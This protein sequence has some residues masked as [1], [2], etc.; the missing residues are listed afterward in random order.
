MTPQ[1]ASNSKRET[2]PMAL[3]MLAVRNWPLVLLGCALGGMLGILVSRMINEKYTVSLLLQIDSQ[4]RRPAG[5]LGDMAEMFQPDARAET[6]TEL[7]QSRA[8]IESVVDSLGLD[9]FSMSK[10]KIRKLMRKSGRLDVVAL[11]I[12]R[13]SEDVKDPWTAVAI[14]D[15]M[16]LLRNPDKQGVLQ[17]RLGELTDTVIGPDTIRFRFDSLKA[18]PGEVFVVAKLPRN[19]VI[20]AILKSL[21][22][23]EKGR[24]TGVLSLT[25]TDRFP[26]RARNVLNAIAHNYVQQN[27]EVRSSD[28]RK[29]LNYLQLQ[30]PKIRHHLDSLEDILKNYQFEKGTVNINS[31]AQA[32]LREQTELQ[33]QAL[34]IQQKR[35]EALRLYRE[36]HPNLTVL[37]NQA[38]Q[39][40]AALAKA[41]QEVKRLPLTQQAVARL[42][43][44]V[45][46]NT[47]LFTAILNNIQQ[48]Q[49]IQGGEVGSARIVDPAILPLRPS[50]LPSK[51]IVIAGILFGFTVV[52]GLL[53]LRHVFD[54]GIEDAASLE[55]ATSLPV[56]AQ[57]P[58]S[59]AQSK[60]SRK[61]KVGESLPL[62]NSNSGDLAVEALRSLRTSLNLTDNAS[63]AKIVTISGLSMGDGKSF[64]ATNVACLFAQVGKRVILIDSDLRR[65][66]LGEQFGIVNQLGLADYLKGIVPEA[67]ILYPTKQPNLVVIPAGQYPSNPAELLSGN[68]MENLLKQLAS[69]A[70]IILL[71]TPPAMMVSDPLF[72]MKLS[73]QTLLVLRAGTHEMDTVQEALRRLRLASIPNVGFVLNKC[74]WSHK[75]MKYYLQYGTYETRNAALQP[76]A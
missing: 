45:E 14:S 62:A 76:K 57:V 12:P 52:Y 50:G 42:S 47:A 36:D 46:V 17:A 26:D 18:E 58:L 65:G 23:V 51:F 35:Q 28:A 4:D 67:S 38:K 25:Y 27:I 70:D 63:Q 21:K 73:T 74:D 75:G 13:P 66:T 55:F 20:G 48:L 31:E 19:D 43:R 11:D 29:A 2:S 16:V 37:D 60:R 54:G 34:S 56:L 7:I 64:V 10:S 3:V 32:V 53:L 41:N 49:V 61:S 22:V 44:D 40:Q 5:P 1:S 68:L 39:V 72:T 71:D 30:M 33:Q 8:V 9:N 59:L 15:S 6:E 24:K 69:K